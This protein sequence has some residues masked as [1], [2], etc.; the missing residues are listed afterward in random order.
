[1][2][3]EDI[4]DVMI[5]ALE[6]GI[7]YWCGECNTVSPPLRHDTARPEEVIAYGGVLEFVDVENPAD[8]ECRWKLT[9]D[10]FMAGVHLEMKE[11]GMRNYNQLMNVLDAS[12]ADRIIQYALF[13]NIIFA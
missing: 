9:K 2:K 8:P 1:M 12:A 7:N 10:K 4:V 5:T 3:K 6:G 13:E 11:R